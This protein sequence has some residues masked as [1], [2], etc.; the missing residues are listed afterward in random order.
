MFR[1]VL[2][3]VHWLT[4]WQRRTAAL[5]GNPRL[6]Y[7]ENNRRP[8]RLASRLP[9]GGR[10]FSASLALIGVLLITACAPLSAAEFAPLPSAAPTVAPIP[11]ATPAP[12]PPP[13]LTPTPTT[14][15]LPSPTPRSCLFSPGT[16]RSAEIYQGSPLTAYRYQLY[17]P[18][19]YDA[20]AERSFPLLVLFH[21]LTFSSQQWVDL[22]LITLSDQLIAAGEIS[23]LVILLPDG[24][25]SFA[26]QDGLIN[27]LLPHISGT[28]RIAETKSERAIGGI[29]A[30]AGWAL[31]MA[32][33]LPAS[34]GAIGLHSPAVSIDESNALSSW[35]ANPANGNPARLWIDIGDADSLMEGAW[36][37]KRSSEGAGVPPAFNVWP[38]GHDSTYWEAHLEQYLRWYAQEWQ[39]GSAGR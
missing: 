14:V 25:S 11:S 13:T 10:F 19:C 26:H 21:G 37:L 5:D 29:S 20:E 32:R 33:K 4:A 3:K 8:H 30:G 36:R 1:V 31:R 16:L 23:P 18:G 24:S 34:F 17:L 28:F 2:A 6:S 12:D 27:V 9:I 15:A 38:G 35:L 7:T 22:G 39:P